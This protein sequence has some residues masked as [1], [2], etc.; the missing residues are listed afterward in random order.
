[1]NAIRS[2]DNHDPAVNPKA[3]Q[4]NSEDRFPSDGE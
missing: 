3:F 2:E 1:M 4:L